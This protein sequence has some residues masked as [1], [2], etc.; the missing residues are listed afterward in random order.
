MIAIIIPA[1]NEE[2]ALPLVLEELQN[3]L[4]TESY[5]IAVGANACSDR[6]VEVARHS[7]VVVGE[8]ERAGYG[9]GCMAAIAA[10]N[11]NCVAQAYLF[12]AADGAGD[13]ADIRQLATAYEGQGEG[14]V[15][16]Q[17][18]ASGDFNL[19]RKAENLLLGIWVGLLCGRIFSDIGPLRIIGRRDFERLQLQELTYGWT[20]EAQILAV[21]LGIP[22]TTIA[23][24][25][26]F[27]VAGSQQVSGHSLRRSLTVGLTIAQAGLR[28]R[29]RKLD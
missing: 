1:R 3:S 9:H 10:A 28:A 29:L 15:I 2:Q 20:I 23:V 6:T 11:E 18:R 27:R 19:R 21:R 22:L 13:P 24:N 17:R 4:S 5:C 25:E 8:T 12:T 26:R 16:G 7:G 14:M